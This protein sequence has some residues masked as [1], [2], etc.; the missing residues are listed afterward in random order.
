MNL[1][2]LKT[3]AIGVVLI[4]QL[5]AF[6]VQSRSGKAAAFVAQQQ[7]EE[8]YR[9]LYSIVEDLQASNVVLQQR[10]ERLESQIN[11]AVKQLNDKQ[12]DTA[13]E[14][15]LEALSRKFTEELQKLE[16]RRTA[17]N[18]RILEEL[19]KL[20]TRPIPQP[21][22]PQKRKPEIEPFTGPVYEIEVQPGYTISAIAQK[23]RDEGH[24]I[25]VNDILRANP[26][27]D[28]RKLKVGQIIKIPARE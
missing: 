14:S 10:I 28:P 2:W 25:Y 27:L 7:A 1:N 9:R 3:V 4:S 24:E 17:D 20:A 18:K 26:G 15:Q 5:P 22:A 11:A 23:Y 13:T 6:A 16:D 8:R 21:P 12:A 19:R